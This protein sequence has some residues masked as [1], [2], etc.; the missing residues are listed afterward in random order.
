MPS[1][2]QRR[3][4]EKER[5]HD[6]EYVY[7]DD[8][9]H[10]LELEEV[11]PEVAKQNGAATKKVNGARPKT[12]TAARGRSGGRTFQPPS[13]SRVLKRALAFA[14]LMGISIWLI[15]R[16]IGTAGIALVTLQMLVI[17]IPFS[18]M[19]DR[20]MYRRSVRQAEEAKAAKPRR[21]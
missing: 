10:E 13:W 5:R 7:V 9:G 4:R 15:D 17:F 1:R 14:P 19:M 20:M 3:R 2:K 11:E 16:G 21:S 18:Y 8:E 12:A 6:Y